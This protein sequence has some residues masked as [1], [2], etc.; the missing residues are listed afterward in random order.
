MNR[1]ERERETRKSETRRDSW[2]DREGERERD[3]L[4]SKCKKMKG[5]EGKRWELGKA[6]GKRKAKN[7]N[8]IKERD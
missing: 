2:T 4:K 5:K 7:R 1:W 3:Q 8:E 6:E